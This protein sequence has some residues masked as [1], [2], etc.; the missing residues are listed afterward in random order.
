MDHDW[1]PLVFLIYMIL[2]LSFSVADPPQQDDPMQPDLTCDYNDHKETSSSSQVQ[3]QPNFDV[4]MD[5]L[6]N[7]VEKQQWGLFSLETDQ[8]L[9]IFSL[10]QCFKDLSA[11]DCNVCFADARQQLS[12][13][14]PSARGRIYS[15]GCFIRYDTY[16]F[17]EEI[18]HT[19]FDH[20][21]CDEVPTAVVGQKDVALQFEDR[22]DML[23]ESVIDAAKV[24][25]SGGFGNARQ[26]DTVPAVY[27]MGQCWNTLNGTGCQSCLESAWKDVMGCLPS[28][29]RAFNAGCY[30]RYSSK[31]FFVSYNDDDDEGGVY[32]DQ[33]Y[34]KY[35]LSETW[36]VTGCAIG[37]FIVVGVWVGYANRR[38]QTANKTLVRIPSA[39]EKSGLNFKYEELEK[40]TDSFSAS[41]K[42]GKGASGAVYKATLP[43]GRT[44]AV[45]RLLYNTR[46]WADDFFNEV[47]LIHGFQHKNLVKLLGCSI[48]GADS[49][50]VYEYMPNSL[51]HLFFDKNDAQELSWKQRFNIVLGIAEGLEHLH[52]GTDV[53][54]VHR[55][56]KSSNILLDENLVPK[57][58]DFGLAR[59]TNNERSHISTGIAGTLGY[60]APEYLLRGQLSEKADVYAFGVLALEIGCGKK[61]NAFANDSD[62]VLLNVW[63]M[64]KSN[65]ITESIDCCNLEDEY[66]QDQAIKVLKVGL[67]CCQ[68]SPPLRPSMGEVVRILIGLS[69]VIPTPKQRPF[70]NASFIAGTGTQSDDT[71]T[72]FTMKN[73]LSSSSTVGNHPESAAIP[74]LDESSSD[75]IV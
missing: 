48:E 33:N 66:Q 38:R 70:L 39:T 55:D 65:R 19:V 27:A 11:G 8:G 50:L 56:I 44:V 34:A 23:V 59:S 41:M 22:A 24:M 52:E 72:T 32:N 30:L 5:N 37:M 3:N 18:I 29:G 43:N 45:K 35:G 64:Y 53:K 7:L 73:P 47:H 71:T 57:I 12:K 60:M 26:R 63:K 10:A 67:L 46:Q 13:C 54:I 62:S 17:Y 25:P 31:K 1:V 58:A 40:A 28:C 14:I 9:P 6:T 42:L 49:M 61:N 68:S 74:K 2:F 69:T 15:D 20:H 36:L 75:D 51:D 4:A 16:K 21:I